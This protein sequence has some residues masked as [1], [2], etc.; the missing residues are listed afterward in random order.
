MSG[1]VKGQVG[2]GTVG[3]AASEGRPRLVGRATPGRNL[4]VFACGTLLAV[5]GGLILFSLVFKP[6]RSEF[7]AMAL[8]LGI[9]AAISLLAGV[10]AYRFGWMRR[11]PRLAWTL[12]AGYL[13]AAAL[14]FVNVLITARLMFLSR[15]DLLLSTVLLVFAAGVAVSIGYLV[16]GS[17]VVAVRKL[18]Q[19]AEEVA[20]GHLDVVVPEQ[21]PEELAELARHFNDMTARLKEAQME[22][23][24]FEQ[25]RRD[26]IM[27][28]GHD[29]R[30]PIASVQV[31]TEAL[32]DGVVDDPATVQRYL[33]TALRDLGTLSRLVD[34]LFVLAQLD[35]GGVQLDRRPNSLTDLVSDTLE[36]FSVRA[37]RQQVRLHG[38]A[39]A[40]IPNLEFDAAYVGRVLANLVDNALRY[41]PPGGEVVLKTAPVHDGVRVQVCDS[42]PGI[43]ARDLP[44][45]FERFYRGE[46]SR[47]RALGGGGLGLAIVKGVVEAHGG[48]V[49]VHV[50]PGAGTTFSFVLPA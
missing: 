10:L 23:A 46:A 43:D 49:G 27:A 18:N 21:G 4:L 47:S 6:P 33:D 48:S 38:E 14:T 22:Q 34:D 13:L 39:L 7:A 30:T 45:V 1:E 29:L 20:R 50:A 9:T 36:A 12:L 16:S 42:G 2:P 28:V 31:I 15:H 3:D 5:A 40:G 26:L 37:E 19:G 25:A 41:T 11:S 32:A 17:V 8:Y 24:A 35:S 44:H